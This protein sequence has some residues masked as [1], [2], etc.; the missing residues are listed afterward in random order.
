[1]VKLI[2]SR[3]LEIPVTL[4]ISRSTPVTVGPNNDPIFPDG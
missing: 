3:N 2:L 1:M 4:E